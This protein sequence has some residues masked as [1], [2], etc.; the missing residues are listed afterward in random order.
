[1]IL[2]DG[3]TEVVF[4]A[5]VQNQCVH[6]WCSMTGVAVTDIALKIHKKRQEERRA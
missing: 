5:P 6:Q 4:S 3:G 1:M 2:K